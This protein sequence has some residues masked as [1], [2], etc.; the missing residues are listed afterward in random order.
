MSS[1]KVLVV[2][3]EQA[4]L[5]KHVLPHQPL[6]LGLDGKCPS[7]QTNTK[8]LELNLYNMRLDIRFKP[9]TSC[10]KTLQ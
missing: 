1:L 9:Y 8:P 7:V 5:T 2:G 10:I 4:L 6:S 3:V